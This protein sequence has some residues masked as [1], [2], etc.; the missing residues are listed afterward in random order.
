CAGLR[1]S[2]VLSLKW[3]DI[4]NTDTL[5]KLEQKT[6]K[7]RQIILNESVREKILELYKL[8]GSP[9]REL[10]AVCNPKT[11]APYSLEYINRQLKVFRV[12]YRLPAK[13]FST[14]TFRKTFGRFVYESNG[15]SAE[16]LILLN[17]IFRHSNIEVTKRYIGIRQDEINQ[18]FN[19]IKF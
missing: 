14:H 18:V 16:S 5:G 19:S 6:Q 4:L 17:T 8:L 12:R 15:R 11:K 10:P 13:A 1:A 7:G 9:G 2:D 3:K